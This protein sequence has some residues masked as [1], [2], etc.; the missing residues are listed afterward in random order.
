MRLYTPLALVLARKTKGEFWATYEPAQVRKFLHGRT[1]CVRS[2]SS[3]AKEWVLSMEKSEGDRR[4]NAHR[5]DLLRKA[6][7]AHI[8][9]A[10]SAA[11]V[12][13]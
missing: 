2:L 5:L 13:E 1:A 6:A 7:E 9:Y 11:E 10:R 8:E 12:G 4:P 3:A